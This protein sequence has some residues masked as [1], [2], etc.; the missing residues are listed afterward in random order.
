MDVH[1]VVHAMATQTKGVGAV[2]ITPVVEGWLVKLLI[3][4][5]L[6]VSGAT[7]GLLSVGLAL[8]QG[9]RADCDRTTRSYNV[10]KIIVKSYL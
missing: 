7:H 8:E 6:Y 3:D 10:P 2:Q 9:F 4:E 5:V 1:G